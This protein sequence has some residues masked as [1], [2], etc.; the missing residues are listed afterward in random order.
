MPKTSISFR[1]PPKLWSDFKEQTDRLFLSRAPFLDH[2]VANE[3]PHLQEDL[4]GVNRRG[5]A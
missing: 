2:M 3:L 1:V 5:S 4:K